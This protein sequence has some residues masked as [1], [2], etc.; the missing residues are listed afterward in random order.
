MTSFT[1]PNILILF[2]SS[3]YSLALFIQSQMEESSNLL[4]LLLERKILKLKSSR[5]LLCSN[6]LSHLEYFLKLPSDSTLLPHVTLSLIILIP[7]SLFSQ[8]SSTT[9]NNFPEDSY[10]W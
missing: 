1:I 9:L 8:L 5:S 7:C 3:E 4:L 6:I 2:Q 10:N